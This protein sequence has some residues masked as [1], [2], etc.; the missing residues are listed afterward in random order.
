VCLT[1]T[2]LGAAGTTVS[3]LTRKPGAAIETPG[4]LGD[5]ALKPE[6]GSSLKELETITVGMIAE[7]DR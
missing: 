5:D 2:V 1:F 3:A 7:L 4:P 6:F